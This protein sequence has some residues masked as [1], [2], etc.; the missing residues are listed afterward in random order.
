MLSRSSCLGRGSGV[1][2]A[3]ASLGGARRAFIESQ[4]HIHAVEL[5]YTNLLVS[6]YLPLNVQYAI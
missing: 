1:L 2:D 5:D 6:F 4:M 3:R